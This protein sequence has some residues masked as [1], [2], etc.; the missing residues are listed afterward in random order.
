[1]FEERGVI[2]R[3]VRSFR[4]KTPFKKKLCGEA[5][6]SALGTITFAL[7]LPNRYFKRF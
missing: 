4:K 6:E 2:Q 1:V 5:G 7:R 3:V